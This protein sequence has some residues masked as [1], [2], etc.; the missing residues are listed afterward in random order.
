MLYAVAHSL[1][2]ERREDAAKARRLGEASASRRR[3]GLEAASEV[4]IRRAVVDDERALFDLAVLS[5]E[6]P[7]AGEILLVEVDGGIRA[8][9]SVGDGRQV[10]DPFRPSTAACDLLELRRKHILDAR[11]GTPARARRFASLR[12]ALRR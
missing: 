1:G 6:R 8:A 7:L 10:S 9:C 4:T 11:A 5:D 12:L 2:H 3:P